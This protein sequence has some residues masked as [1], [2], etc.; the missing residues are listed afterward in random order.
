MDREITVNLTP[1]LIRW[2][3]FYQLRPLI[4]I[5]IIV[6]LGLSF[7]SFTAFSQKGILS[8]DAWIHFLPVLLIPAFFVFAFYSAYSKN[9]A[10]VRKMKT[11][12]VKY[13]ITDESFYVES[14][15]TQGKTAW[16]AYKE[17]RKNAKLWQ[18]VVQGG[19]AHILPVELLDEEL[20]SFLSAKLPKPS[21]TWKRSSFTIF[22]IWL[23]L[24]VVVYFFFR[25]GRH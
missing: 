12:T 10:Q 14:D 6:T 3:L 21:R 7:D 18:V 16:V 25:Q 8:M 19:S 11:P 22:A 17:L 1:R 13:R 9:L 15:L 2:T 24:L 4:A 20:K 5:F 23:L